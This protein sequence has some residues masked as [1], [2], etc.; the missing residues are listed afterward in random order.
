M[1]YTQ[2]PSQKKSFASKTK[3]WEKDCIDGAEAMALYSYGSLRKSYNEKRI[4]YNLYAN[5]L[6]END[7]RQIT[8]PLN[9]E[10]SYTPAKMQNYPIINPKIDLLWGEESKRM[11]DWRVRAINAD[12]ISIKERKLS[13]KLGEIIAAEMQ[14]DSVDKEEL[15]KKLKEFDKY[16]NFTYQD[17]RELM[18][19]WILKHLW[20][21]QN[22]K[23]KLD[24][25][26]K[27]GLLVAEEIY[28]WDI[29]GTKPVLIKHNP[30]NVFTV[31]SGE[32]NRIED[33]EIIVVDS[34][35][36]PGKI[37]DEYNE[38]LTDEQIK[39]IEERAM[40]N[41]V[42]GNT[43]YPDMTLDKTNI[44]Q[45][46]DSTID[47]T[48]FETGL[49]SYR[50]PFDR[51]GNVRVVKVYWKSMR[52]MIK[53][54][55]YDEQGDEQY[56][57]MPETYK[58]DKN[59]GEE[60]KVI[61]INEW[62]EGH[63]IATGYTSKDKIYVR[64]QVK[65]VQFRRLENPSECQSGFVG[66]IYNTNDNIAVSLYDRMKPYQYM[67]NA[68]MYNIELLIA[69]NW[70]RIMKLDTSL[71]PDG[72]ETEKW[73]SYA[74]YLKI[75]PVDP[76]KEGN[77]GAATGKLAGNMQSA[78]ANP[79]IDMEQGNTIQ[80][81]ISMMEHIQQEVGKIAGVSGAREGE[82]APS[83]SVGNTDRSYVQSTHTTEYYFSVHNDVKKR[84]LAVGLE[85]AKMAW[86]DSK[87]KKLQYVTDD[88]I[89]K[90]VTI[91]TEDIA[92]I[93]FDIAISNSREDTNLKEELKQLAHA[94]IQTG[95]L[96]FSQLIDILNSSSVSE[97]GRKIEK[98]EQDRIER[99]QKNQEQ[100]YKIEQQK[101][102]SVQ[103]EAQKE[104]DLKVEL[105]NIK[106]QTE[107]TLAEL[108]SKLSS[109]DKNVDFN[110]NGIVDN[111]EMDSQRLENQ[112]DTEEKQKE[113]EFEKEQN[114][115]DRELKL[116]IEKMKNDK[117]N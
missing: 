26:F 33:S 15:Q 44:E 80:L 21:E 103:D 94:G 88:M 10:N 3:K 51:N 7:V 20:T 32:S 43:T 71:I 108:K 1:S 8:D 69:T 25:G 56:E 52:K 91:K 16:K 2:F 99:E 13:V 66:S 89:T 81:Y 113:R 27:D 42:Y 4:N 73:I 87:T 82:I 41:N 76:F 59:K 29:V 109:I 105:E 96:N 72:W 17:E 55:Y 35:Y 48:I 112:H 47:S 57:L 115:K 111:V 38:Y 28:Q 34:Y 22:I 18:G 97:I 12:A 75:A 50:S 116:K 60:G 23:I 70:G 24:D 114:V 19:T 11:F 83:A 102:K 104:R 45:E 92:M 6:D 107:I 49:N 77:K 90:M 95:A 40:N 14:K 5:I 9:L 65:P 62:R 84:V 31:R 58:V 106:A 93:D 30:M 61:W 64:M 74:K 36:P 53:V 46:L 101:I 86:K 100:Q 67:Y 98:A 63:E 79:V 117:K 54:K 78:N 68:L 85:V 39:I 37:I 110:H